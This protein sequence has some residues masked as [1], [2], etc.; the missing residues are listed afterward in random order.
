MRK[1][2]ENEKTDINGRVQEGE[3]E[4][5]VFVSPCKPGSARLGKKERS[6]RLGSHRH[7]FK[8]LLVTSQLC[9]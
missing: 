7:G 5:T 4:K 9:E 2:N 1:K 6:L 8:F 3:G